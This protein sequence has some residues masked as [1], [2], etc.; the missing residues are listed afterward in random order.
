MA[1]VNFHA[2]F[3]EHDQFDYG[4]DGHFEGLKTRGTGQVPNGFPV[5]YQAKASQDWEFEQDTV[6]YDLSARAYNNI[7]DR[8]PQSARM[9][10]LLLCLPPVQQDWHHVDETSTVIRNCCYWHWF[11]G[12]LVPNSSTKRVWI[13]RDQLFTPQALNDLLEIER[14]RILA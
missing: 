7:V 1:Q 14:Y 2:T 11:E 8:A 6:R 9:I 10:L 3:S 12:E 5:L 13:P 4:V